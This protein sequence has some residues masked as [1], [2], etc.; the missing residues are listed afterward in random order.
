MAAVRRSSRWRREKEEMELM[1]AAKGASETG[2][3]ELLAVA[4]DEG[5]GASNGSEEELLAA[6]IELSLLVRCL[7]SERWQLLHGV[8]C[9]ISR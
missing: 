6:D 2:K 8:R 7:C 5:V 9:E 1:A 4:R 3:R